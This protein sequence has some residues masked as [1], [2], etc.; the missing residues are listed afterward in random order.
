MN[1]AATAACWE[2]HTA[3]LE[4]PLFD[5]FLEAGATS[6]QGRSDDL[7]GFKPEGLARLDS[8][9]RDGRRCSAAVPR[10]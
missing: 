9:I 5:A 10:I 4:N 3:K 1:G 7:N 8:T 2:F 6:G